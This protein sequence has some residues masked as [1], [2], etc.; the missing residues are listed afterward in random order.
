MVDETYA[1][2]VII[3]FCQ[4]ALHSFVVGNLTLPLRLHVSQRAEMMRLVGQEGQTVI[5]RY[6]HSDDIAEIAHCLAT[7]QGHIEAGAIDVGIL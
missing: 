2:K 1:E 5:F 7:V 3:E 4:I 6:Q